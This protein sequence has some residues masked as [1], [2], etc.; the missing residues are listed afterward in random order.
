LRKPHCLKWSEYLEECAH[1]LANAGEVDTDYL[2]GYYIRFQH[3][4]E[5]VNEAFAYDSALTISQSETSRIDF[6]IRGFEQQLNN[7]KTTA[8]PQIWTSSELSA[9]NHETS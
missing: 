3:V 1:S 5:E 7:F 6:L 8:P 4:A 2:L 9:I